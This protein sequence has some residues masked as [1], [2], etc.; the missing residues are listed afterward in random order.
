QV[1]RSRRLGGRLMLASFLEGLGSMYMAGAIAAASRVDPAHVYPPPV[2][3]RSALDALPSPPGRP[4]VGHLPDFARDTLGFVEAAAREHGD[5]VRFRLGRWEAV[6]LNHP[7]L[8]EE[9]LVRDPWN[10]IKHTFFWRH[11][12]AI[13]GKGL[14]TNEGQPWLHQRRLVQPAF[15]HDRLEAYA[16]TMVDYTLRRIERWEDG[17]EIDVRAE[18]TSLTF[19]IVAKVLFDADVAGDVAE[20]GAAFDTGIEEIGRRFRRPI[21]IPD[22]VPTPG[23]LRYRRSVARM[24]ALIERIVAEHREGCAGPDDLLSD[25]MAARD[26]EGRPMPEEQL[27]D[28]VITLLLAG[29]ETTALALTWTWWLLARHPGV[30]RRL[31]D[32]VEAAVG[33]GA[34]GVADVPRLGYVEH[35]VKESMRLRPPAYSF[36]REAVEPCEVGGREIPAG[37]TVFVFPWLL[38]RDVRWFEKPLTF[39][40][41]RWEGELEESLPRAAYLPFGAGPRICVGR[42]FAMIEAVLIVATIAARW[43]IEWGPADPRPFPSITLRPTGGLTARLRSR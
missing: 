10:W 38:H 39:D 15:R 12:G 19:E 13:F 37:T 14:L 35:V 16:A 40:P 43:R 29:H 22:R 11:V 24:D 2:A 30:D 5:M 23:N 8:V 7:Y 9:V 26:E 21:R 25:L 33:S 28:E 27:R 6:L 36:G 42:H 4:L 1:S 32:A 20:I 17:A 31:A 18:M 34:P 3:A 41:D